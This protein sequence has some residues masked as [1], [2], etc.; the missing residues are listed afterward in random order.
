MNALLIVVCDC[1]LQCKAETPRSKNN[2]ATKGCSQNSF[3]TN[4]PKAPGPWFSRP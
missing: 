2:N 1:E 3:G 4:A